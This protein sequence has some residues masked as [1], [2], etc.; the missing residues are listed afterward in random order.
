LRVV[1]YAAR[2]AFSAQI[3]PMTSHL[4]ELAH[5]LR[6]TRGTFYS[7]MNVDGHISMIRIGLIRYR[8]K[9]TGPDDLPPVQ[10]G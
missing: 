7:A 1:R 6:D 8:S 2:P 5:A 9:P 3:A 4:I 10:D